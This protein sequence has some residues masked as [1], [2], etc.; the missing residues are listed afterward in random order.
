MEA[1]VTQDQ[2]PI[3]KDLDQ[4][5]KQGIVDVGRCRQPADDARPSVLLQ[6]KLCAGPSG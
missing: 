6:Y 5:V 2:H 3:L 4:G 1:R